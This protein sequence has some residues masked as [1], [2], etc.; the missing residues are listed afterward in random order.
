MV[1][2]FVIKITLTLLPNHLLETGKPICTRPHLAYIES[3]A[4]HKYLSSIGKS[5][6]H[7]SRSA[8]GRST[9]NNVSGR[10]KWHYFF[11]LPSSAQAQ[12]QLGAEIAL[13]SQLWGTTIRH[14]KPYTLHAAR[15]S[16][17]ACLEPHYHNCG[18]LF[19]TR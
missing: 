16:S 18:D 5:S 6:R 11:F 4:L 14:P 10:Y 17:L 13:F 15:N 3:Y 8:F 19:M 12:A 9:C 2:I 7:S 1:E